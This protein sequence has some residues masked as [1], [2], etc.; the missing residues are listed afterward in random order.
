[1][2]S[3]HYNKEVFNEVT[4]YLNEQEIPYMVEKRID[5]LCIRIPLFG[6]DFAINMLSYGHELGLLEYCGPTTKDRSMDIIPYCD[7]NKVIKIIDT[8]KRQ[9]YCS[10]YDVR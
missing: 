9:G 2:E 3:S 4:A 7:K 10:E 1:M 8:L 6:C 5:G